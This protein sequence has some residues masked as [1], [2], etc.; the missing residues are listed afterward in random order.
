MCLH[1]YGDTQMLTKI[2]LLRLLQRELR[3]VYVTEGVDNVGAQVGGD[4]FRVELTLPR[5][6]LSP[7]R[8][9]THD[10]KLS[11]CCQGDH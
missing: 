10:T 7:V 4:V 5:P 3:W 2:V 1:C 6:V 8:V 9:V 11:S